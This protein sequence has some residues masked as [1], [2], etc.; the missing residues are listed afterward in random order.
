M[1]ANTQ[2]ATLGSPRSAFSA[3]A[4]E[5]CPSVDARHQDAIQIIDPSWC[6]AMAL[7]WRRTSGLS[8]EP[9]IVSA[10]MPSEISPDIVFL[11]CDLTHKEQLDE[12]L[13]RSYADLSAGGML[14]VRVNAKLL[15][16]GGLTRDVLGAALHRAGFEQPIMWAGRGAL[17]AESKGPSWLANMLPSEALGSGPHE[18]IFA[19]IRRTPTDRIV[20]VA[21][22]SVLGPMSSRR[23]LL[24]V[25]LPVYNEKKTFTT[26]MDIL[27]AKEIPD[28]DIE[29]CVVE[30]NS[31][32]GTRE[33]VKR[34][35]GFPRVRIEWEEKAKGK[36]HAVR[37]GLKM[38]RGDVVLIQDADLEY[39]LNDYEKLIRPVLEGKA[40]FILGSR[41][42]E[43]DG[44]LNMR[45]FNDQ[46]SLG[47]LFN[48][49]H[50][51]FTGLL[52][53]VF[54]QRLADPFTM[55]KVFRRDCIHNLNFECNRFDFDHELVGKLIRN[56]FPPVEIGVSYN[57]R[58][59]T[60]GKKVSMFG[61]PPLWV[62]ALLKHRFSKLHAWRGEA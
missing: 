38:A 2:A 12:A 47:K 4:G 1:S 16:R 18:G 34:Y 48:V 46:K 50:V 28:T 52:N 19:S 31:T 62:R 61:D 14:W 22:K 35:E 23:P 26:V 56:G 27:L 60:E 21:R 13:A 33:D 25:V 20:A 51:I 8:T 9:V 3:A 39:D 29:I 36:G 10:H 57:S 37:T 55:F 5:A 59:F 30:S 58:S 17:I 15:R 42:N 6:E 53:G 7:Y 11:D 54:L 44:A 45:K 24:S 49:G 40:S 41:H 43:T 32:D